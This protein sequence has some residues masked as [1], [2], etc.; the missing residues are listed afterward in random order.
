VRRSQVLKSH[1]NIYRETKNCKPFIGIISV[2]LFDIIDR[3]LFKWQKNGRSR[4]APLKK[5]L[6]RL[7]AAQ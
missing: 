7:G 1:K 3:F 2:C 4:R 5:Y 6:K